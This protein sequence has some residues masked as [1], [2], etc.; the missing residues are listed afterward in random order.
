MHV[1]GAPAIGPHDRGSE[2]SAVD[3][4][5]VRRRDDYTQLF[6]QASHVPAHV[7]QVSS[8]AQRVS[9]R[10]L[11][12]LSKLAEKMTDPAL[13]VDTDNPDI[14]AGYTYLAQFVAHDMT[15]NLTAFDDAR[16]PGNMRRNARH[17]RL[18]LQSLYGLGPTVSPHLYHTPDIGRSA[19]GTLRLGQMRKRTSACPMSDDPW[20]DLPRVKVNGHADGSYNL[21]G[22]V[23]R[24][25]V[26]DGRHDT[27]SADSRNDDNL[28][29]S[30]LTVLF[31][32]LHNTLYNRL[33][34]PSIRAKL[35][36]HHQDPR[37]QFRLARDS[38]TLAY[39]RVIFNHLLK[40]LLDPTVYAYFQQHGP[41]EADPNSER[42]IPLEFSHAAYRVGH[43]MIRPGYEMNDGVDADARSFLSLSDNLALGSLRMSQ[44]LPV[45]KDWYAQWSK[46]F[47]TAGRS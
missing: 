37:R 20:I 40:R 4:N 32:V 26:I 12:L 1:H 9:P 3:H 16:G 6:L 29:V 42:G 36:P 13:G 15:F 45:I 25:S 35:L 23:Q 43:A 5:G 34:E 33:D 41:L 44:E 10:R 17:G 2:H 24:S 31:S 46:F 19:R 14:P 22:S 38:V 30:Q 7:P 21:D 18:V 11:A 28:I 8:S 39:R 47:E 27:L